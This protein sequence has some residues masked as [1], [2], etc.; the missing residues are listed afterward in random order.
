MPHSEFKSGDKIREWAEE[1][2]R[3]VYFLVDKDPAKQ[4]EIFTMEADSVLR[5]CDALIKLTDKKTCTL[6]DDWDD[7]PYGSEGPR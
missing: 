5:L 6:P 3:R 2:R 1:A 4:K 7:C